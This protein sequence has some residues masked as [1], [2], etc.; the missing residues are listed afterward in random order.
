MLL[1]HGISPLSEVEVHQT[2]EEL[3]AALILAG[4]IPPPEKWGEESGTQGRIE[5][6]LRDL[7]ERFRR[8][9][10]RLQADLRASQESAGSRNSLTTQPGQRERQ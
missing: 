10:E 9:E 6:G 4:K 7:Q 1:E 8:R 5:A 2:W 3:T